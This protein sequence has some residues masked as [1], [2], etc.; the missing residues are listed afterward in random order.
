VATTTG[1]IDL[2]EQ[3]ITFAG[4]LYRNATTSVLYEHAVLRH[5]ARIAEGGPFVVDT[6]VHT[7]R[8]PKD[9]FAVREPESEDR[10]WWGPVNGE[11]SLDHYEGL[12]AKVA[13]YLGGLDSLSIVDAFAGADP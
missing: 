9:K 13:D 2:R 8:S 4:A 10:I 3:G 6:G 1:Q 12:R 11:L 7:G 5:E